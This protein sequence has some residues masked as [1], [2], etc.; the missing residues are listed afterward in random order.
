MRDQV[1]LAEAGPRLVPARAHDRDLFFQQRAGFGRPTQAATGFVAAACELAIDGRGA[2]LAQVA[3]DAGRDDELAVV[4]EHRN[5]FGH[6]RPQPLAARVV[7]NHPDFF[8]VVGVLV[9][10][11]APATAARQERP[12]QRTIEESG[13]VL[14]LV[15]GGAAKLLEHAA[16]LGFGRVPVAVVDGGE[17][18]AAGGH[19]QGGHR[20][21][22]YG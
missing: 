15:A 5:H 22:G 6:H 18:L 8:Q 14:V 17:V 10:V 4:R 16:L 11:G 3:G 21:L 7:Q 20:G 9:G 12:A 19:R 1:E 2:H 13:G